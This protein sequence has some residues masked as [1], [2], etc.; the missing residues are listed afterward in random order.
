MAHNILTIQKETEIPA[1]PV[2]MVRGPDDGVMTAKD[3]STFRMLREGGW[4]PEDN[5]LPAA[6]T[7][8]DAREVRDEGTP[9]EDK[10]AEADAEVRQAWQPEPEPEAFDLDALGKLAA[11]AVRTHELTPS[12]V[13][14]L[15]VDGLQ[16]KPGI[17][18]ATA[19]QLVEAAG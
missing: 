13:R 2:H 11:D 16:L 1:L 18:P 5:S 7:I 17:G 14:E 3:P 9:T 6:P 19:K 8:T 15:G 12:L 10:V 4:V